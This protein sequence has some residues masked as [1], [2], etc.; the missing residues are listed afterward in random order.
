VVFV[1]VGN[2]KQGFRRLLDAVDILA[3]AGAFN[4]ES[5]FIQSGHNS[6]FSP[7]NCEHEPFIDMDTFN[8]LME[9]AS[10]I[11]CHGGC[12]QLQ[13]VQLRKVP[14]VMPRMSKYNEHVN[15]HQVQLVEALASEGLIVPTYVPDELAGAIAEAR[16]RNHGPIPPPSPM[17]TLV[18][19][20][21]QDLTE[22]KNR[23]F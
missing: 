18:K 6:G 5:V 19:Q 2:A 10:L 13:A 23:K 11:I 3:G 1:T 17:L 20:A 4:G 12:T 9:D 22:G 8:R 21:V 16:R 15:D 7:R 14:V